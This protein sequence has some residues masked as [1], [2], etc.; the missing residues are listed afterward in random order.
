MRS[1]TCQRVSQ[2]STTPR[3][4]GGVRGD[5]DTARKKQDFD[6]WARQRR[7]IYFTRDVCFNARRTECQTICRPFTSQA[8]LTFCQTN[9]SLVFLSKVNTTNTPDILSSQ[10]HSRP[11]LNSICLCCVH[12]KCLCTL[13]KW[14]RRGKNAINPCCAFVNWSVYLAYWVYL[15]L[16]M[17][18]CRYTQTWPKFWDQNLYFL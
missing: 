4:N 6:L 10:S 17:Y 7:Q 16:Q 18:L 11:F 3:A 12:L 13:D 1:R 15:K 8:W 5:R 9:V 14:A 2:Q